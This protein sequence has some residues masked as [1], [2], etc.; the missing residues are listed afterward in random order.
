MIEKKNI[1]ILI[2]GVVNKMIPNNKNFIITKTNKILNMDKF[3]RIINKNKIIKKK[4]QNIN[5]LI[6]KT[7]NNNY[8]Y[9]IN[10]I[11]KSKIIESHIQEQLL[12]DYFTSKKIIKI[13]ETKSKIFLNQYKEGDINY[14]LR[15]VKKLKFTYKKI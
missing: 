4:I 7:E 14:L 1:R 9:F 10:E 15:Y 11:F 6:K 2:E 3:L 13:L 12:E 8:E 5:N